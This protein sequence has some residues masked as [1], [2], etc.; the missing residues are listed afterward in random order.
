[1]KDRIEHKQSRLSRDSIRWFNGDVDEA[2]KF[3]RKLISAGRKTVLIVDP[4]F[5]RTELAR[6][7]L[8]N[9]TRGVTCR[10]LTSKMFLR[11]N[12]EPG[13]SRQREKEF[14]QALQT[15][16]SLDSTNTVE[17]RVMAGDKAPIHDRFVHVDSHLWLLGSSLNEFGSRG[18]TAVQLSH[19]PGVAADLELAWDDAQPLADFV[20]ERPNRS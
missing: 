12:S 5:D 4:Y 11:D 2:T 15:F 8:A 19:A 14:L 7:T 1:V 17:V 10:V 18:T 16:A 13:K 9:A 6:F 20:A 3:V